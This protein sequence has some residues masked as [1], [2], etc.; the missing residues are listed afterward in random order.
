MQT[1]KKIAVTGATG[2]LGRPLVELL[3]AGGHEVVPISRT[4]GVDVITGEGLAD[5]LSGVDVII[6]AATGPSPD[7]AEATAFFATA[8]RN[9]QSEAARAGV[10]RIVLVSIIGIDKFSAGYNVAKLAQERAHVDGPVPVTILRAAQFHEFV[11]ELMKWGTQGDVAYLWRMRT[12]L[13]AARTV[14]EALVALAVAPGGENGAIT[15]IAG[16]RE[17]QLVDAATRLAA[18]RGG[19]ARVE[20]VEPPDPQY[21]AGAALPN[22]GATLAGPTFDEWLTAA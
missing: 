2:R 1:G 4:H 7:E 10:E 19:P 20:G 6:D 12:Q 17:E 8:A 13:V 9:I 21:L 11:G 3:E 18:R 5:A 15:E 14:A 16:P 22:P